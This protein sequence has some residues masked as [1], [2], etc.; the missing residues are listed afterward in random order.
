[1]LRNV[2]GWLIMLYGALQVEEGIFRWPVRRK[3]RGTL[4]PES[5]YPD[6]EKWHRTGTG[7]IGVAFLMIGYSMTSQINLVFLAVEITIA[8]AGLF[9]EVKAMKLYRGHRPQ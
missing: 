7:F 4:P 5:R 8:V 1:M 2:I 6:V 3:F 9:M